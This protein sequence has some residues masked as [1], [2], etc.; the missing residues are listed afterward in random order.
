MLH[1]IRELKDNPVGTLNNILSLLKT[2]KQILCQQTEPSGRLAD[3][4]AMTHQKTSMPIWTM[5]HLSYIY[6]CGAHKQT[7]TLLQVPQCLMDASG[8]IILKYW[9]RIGLGHWQ[10]I[11]SVRDND[12]RTFRLA[13]IG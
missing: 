8:L 12:R 13:M 2:T 3:Y 1:L 9:F 6:L 7:F 4:S 10:M 5:H 11:T